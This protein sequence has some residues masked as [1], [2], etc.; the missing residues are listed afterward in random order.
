MVWWDPRLLILN[1]EEKMGLRQDKLLQADENKLV[2]DRGEKMHDEWTAKQ[3]GDARGGHDAEDERRDCDRTCAC[4]AGGRTRIDGDNR[5]R[6]DA[7]RQAGGRMASASAR[8]C[9]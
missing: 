4:G 8:S 6:R 9:I 7:A 2:S 3:V 5:D 1:V